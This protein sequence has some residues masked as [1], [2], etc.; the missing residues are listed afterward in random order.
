MALEPAIDGPP[1]WNV[2]VMPW[3]L[4]QATIGA[5]WAPVFTPPRPIS[6][7]SVTPASAMSAKS[8]SSNPSSRIGAPAW[9]LTPAGRKFW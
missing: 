4:A 9:T 5:A 6:P 8:R 1:V 3:V 7:T 2:T